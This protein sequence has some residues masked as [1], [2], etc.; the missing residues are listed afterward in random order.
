MVKVVVA[1]GGG[2]FTTSIVT[3]K[4]DEILKEEQ[5]AHVITPH[6]LVEIPEIEDEDLIVVTSKTSAVNNAGIPVMLG[7]ALFTGVDEAAFTEEFVAK[8]KE[9]EAA[10]EQ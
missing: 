7:S 2:V 3:E 10:K 8:I 5:I 9:I 1:C 6:K 4:I